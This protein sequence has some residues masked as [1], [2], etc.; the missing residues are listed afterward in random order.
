[1]RWGKLLEH[2]PHYSRKEQGTD[3]H[4]RPFPMPHYFSTHSR[5]VAPQMATL[6]S[7][8]QVM[9]GQT[10]QHVFHVKLSIGMG[11]IRSSLLAHILLEKIR[12]HIAS[13][14]LGFLQFTVLIQRLTRRTQGENVLTMPPPPQMSSSRALRSILCLVSTYTY[15]FSGYTN[16]K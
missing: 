8:Y 10:S 4:H 15:L 5:S 7:A 6:A 14:I 12:L 3:I 13:T 9:S 2:Y 16:M 1:M 11:K